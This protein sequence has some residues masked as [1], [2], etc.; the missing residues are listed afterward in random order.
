MK[1]IT[2]VYRWA[3][4]MVMV[5]DQDGQQMPEYQGLFEYVREKIER[6]AP[7]DAQF[8]GWTEPVKWPRNFT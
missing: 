6:D 2:Y 8:N 3:N 1:R 5:C 4:G 7:K